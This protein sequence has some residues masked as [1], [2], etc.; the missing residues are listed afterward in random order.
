MFT[1]WLTS[2]PDNLSQWSL[3]KRF[4]L[5]FATGVLCV[6]AMP[7]HGWWI[8]LGLGF[9]LLFSLLAS[10][11]SI[12]TAFLDGWGFAFGYFGFGLSW[13]A[14]ALLVDGNPF[15]WAWPLAIAGLPALLGLF[16]GLLG[17][18]L[19]LLTPVRSWT[20]WC[21]FVGGA[22]FTEWLRGHIFTGFPWNIFGYAWNDA[23]AMA[24][25]VSLFGSYGLTALTILFAS[26]PA[27][28]WLRIGTHK[29]RGL[30]S[31]LVCLFMLCLFLWGHARLA[32][33]P[34]DFRGDIILR[35]VQPNIPQADKWNYQLANE[36]FRKL[37]TQ[38][39]PEEINASATT[40]MIWPETAVIERAIM[41]PETTK[42]LRD[43]LH[44]YP[45]D[46][47]LSTGIL[48]STVSTEGKTRYYNSLV[49][50]D[51]NLRVVTSYDKA[52]LVPFG[53]YIPY[54]TYIPLKPVTA[55]EGF[56]AGSGPQ[57]QNIDRRINISPLI[58]YEVIFPGKTVART[59]GQSDLM[60]NVTNDAWYGDSAGP[61]QHLAMGRFRA[62][63]E[64]VPLARSANTGIS[65]LFDAYGRLIA[66]APLDK[67][68]A[69]NAA[70][71][72]TATAPYSRLGDLPFFIFVISLLGIAA[73]MRNR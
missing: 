1:Q 3:K 19:K 2:F 25:T 70:L 24:Q 43:L 22:A 73:F 49:T 29:N 54:R 65:G 42:I 32:E 45:R 31:G 66:Q 67:A 60:V 17:A 72:R 59:H 50:Y 5:A 26:L 61:R 55:F 15:L 40:I 53:E 33:N 23:L 16:Y 44:S 68:M 64:A 13:I 48:R 71:P 27:L 6:P 56:E 47:Y 12:K 58:C 51:K 10:T 38:S 57:T 14:N 28:W 21:A 37:L 9:S 46:V 7:P 39:Q 30:V 69:L 35:I 41:S 34:P 20:G 62:I 63:E 8:V 18:A 52:H 36:N 4:L 11:R